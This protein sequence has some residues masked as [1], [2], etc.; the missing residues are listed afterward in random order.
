MEVTYTPVQVICSGQIIKYL[1]DSETYEVFVHKTPN[2]SLLSN[3][4]ATAIHHPGLSEN[5]KIGDYVKLSMMFNFEN[6]IQNKFVGPCNIAGTNHIIGLYNERSLL[7]IKVENPLTHHSD[8]LTFVNKNNGAGLAIDDDGSTRLVSG[9]NFILI[10]GFGYGINQDSQF[11]LAQ[12]HIKTIAA[13]GPYYTSKEHFGMFSGSSL[14]DQVNRTTDE[15]FPIIYRRFVSQSMDIKNWVS[16]CEGTFAPWFGPNNNH[17]YVQKSKDVLFT[18]IIN[19]NKSRVTLE[20]GEPGKFINLR[21][22][23]VIDLEQEIPTGNY[24][25]VTGNFGNRFSLTVDEKG[26]VDIRAAGKG[27]SVL[28][29][30]THGFH[31]SIDSDGNLTMK[32]SGKIT[33]THGDSDVSN[34]S[35]VLDPK[36][37]IDIKANKGFRVNG[38][39][40]VTKNFLDWFKQNEAT[41]CMVTAIGAPA[42]L[43]NIPT[44]ETGYNSTGPEGFESKNVALPAKGDNPDNVT[45]YSI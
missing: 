4:P 12:N 2:D 43:V 20:V 21:I 13:N 31:L 36:N 16:T 29:G 1:A 44:F 37:G 28:E 25:A 42:P 10:K 22:D 30:N 33:L 38:K 23:D 18:K 6:G 27:K 15:D 14:E 8:T 35:I 11:T 41:M 24:G 34:N 26:S 32:S 3:V 40:L 39:E 45:F 5:Y 9:S 17:D 7:N 19:N